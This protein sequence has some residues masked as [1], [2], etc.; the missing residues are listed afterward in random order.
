[1]EQLY[2]DFVSKVLPQIQAGLVVTK[3]YF[4]DLAGRYI[5]YLIIVDTISLVISLVIL[6][7]VTYF[8]FRKKT[9][10]WTMKD[11]DNMVVYLFVVPAMII[12]LAVAFSSGT[13][14]VKDIY[15]PEI[16]ILEELKP[17]LN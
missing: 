14:L 9:R 15:I 8:G 13:N 6:V 10:E 1:M 2:N 11:D 4:M 12:T 3:E 16:R 5:T 17:F 7:L